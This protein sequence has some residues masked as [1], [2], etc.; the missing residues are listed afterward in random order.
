MTTENAE[1]DVAK[2]IWREVTASRA[3][4]VVAPTTR[5]LCHLT[6]VVLLV[7]ASLL[8][9][10]W[11]TVAAS[12]VVCGWWFLGEWRYQSAR[13]DFLLLAYQVAP[14]DP[15]VASVAQDG[16]SGDSIYHL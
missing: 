6:A 13:I 7:V 1:R 9:F 16:D 12:V 8:H 11:W 2:R 15:T 14:T 4:A 10:S 5:I 3:T